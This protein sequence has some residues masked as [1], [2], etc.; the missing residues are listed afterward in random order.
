MKDTFTLQEIADW[1]LDIK[2]SIV[3]L[4]PIQRGF[5]WKPKQIEDLWDSILRGYPIGS[6]LFSK[7]STNLHLMDG[8]QRATSIFLGH[9]N[10]YKATEAT[11]SWSIKGELPV[12]WLDINPATKPVTSKYL[13][14]LTTRSHP[15]GYQATNNDTKL[16]VSDRKKALDLFQKHPDNTRGYTTFKNTTTFPFDASYPIPLAF[17]IESKNVGEIIAKAEEFLP[18]YFSTLRADFQN[19]S[20]FV[21]LLKTTLSNELNE[22]FNSIKE[23]EELKIKSNI[24]EDRVLQEENEAE[25]PTLF[26]RINS[27]GTTLTGDDL[28]FSIY[29]AIFPEAKD[30]MENIGMDFITP[31]Q[32]LSLASRIVNSDL[33]SNKFTKK[34]N[35]REFQRKIKSDDF[36]AGLKNQIETEQLKNLFEQAI[37]IM[38]CENNT[39][40][41]GKIPPVII[42]QFIKRNQELFLFFVYWLRINKIELTDHIKLKMVGKLLAFA[43]FDFANI[44]RLWDK[45]ITNNN[46]WEEPINELMWWDNKD[47]IHFLIKPDLLRD[48]YAQPHIEKMFIQNNKD[49]WGL[50]EEGTGSKI[51]LY[52]E[53]VKGQKYDL[54][55]ANDYFWKFIGRI[56]HNKQLILL[57]QREYINASFG[58]Y[59]QM[60]DVDDTNVPW[61]W[62]HI[63]PSEWVYRKGTCNQ[64]IRDW[65]NTNGNFRALS[66][67]QNRSEGKATPKGRLTLEDSRE[68]SFVKD[69]WQYWQNINDR[70]WNDEVENHFRAITTRMINIY[71][72][73]WNDFKINELINNNVLPSKVIENTIN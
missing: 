58:D 49:R 46:F 68:I 57:A 33:D 47:G 32:V 55:T 50:W 21:S 26:V 34:I 42:K 45:E 25:D 28:I 36:K 56:Q 70:I 13:F 44:P 54:S 4:P 61:D 7:T 63:Y 19:K 67:E 27:S 16:R 6:F 39:L 30:L 59:N 69:D 51:K 2:N 40:F 43:W 11:K 38:S 31:T 1:Q 60:D 20:E 3:E 72:I 41:D 71:E 12:L 52:F 48:Y 22:M 73:F 14:R 5:V 35:V 24:I 65:N 64:S 23:I 9:F 62:D 15:W 66:L 37:E 8:Q 18:E 10:P 53:T 17:F 29:K